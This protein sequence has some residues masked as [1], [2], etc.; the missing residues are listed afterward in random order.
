MNFLAHDVV[1]PAA[2]ATLTRVGASLPDLWALLPRRALPFAIVRGLRENADPDA[3][4][5]ADGIESHLR[6]DAVFHGHSQFQRRVSIAAAELKQRMPALRHA[7]LAAHVA[8]EMVFDRWLMDRDPSAVDRFYRAFEPLAIE[9]ASRLGAQDDESRAVLRQ[10]LDRFVSSAF[11]RAY[12]TSEGIVTRWLR[13]LSRTPFVSNRDVD[14]SWLAD[15]VDGWCGQ[16]ASE[17]SDLLEDVR[18]GVAGWKGRGQG[19]C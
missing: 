12:G 15:L 17:S 3:G 9:S 8:V 14:E 4:L 11:L 13:S 5:L 16:F 1:L 6:A 19:V 7:H 2:S 10:V 18:R